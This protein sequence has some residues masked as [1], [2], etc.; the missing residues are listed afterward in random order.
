MHIL[1]TGGAGFIGSNLINTLFRNNPGIKITCIDNFDPFYSADIKQLNIKDFQFNPD[2]HFLYN[3][4]ATTSSK[5]LCEL[6]DD[7]VDTI[8]HIA[9]KAGVRPSILN[10]LAY[11]QTNVIGMQHLLEFAKEKRSKTICFCIQQQCVWD[12]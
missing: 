7:H 5:E 6:I 8:V 2:F 10:P 1:V 12:Q 9:A 4:L 11:Q 3:D